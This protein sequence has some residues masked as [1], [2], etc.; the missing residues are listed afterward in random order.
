MEQLEAR[1]LSLDSL[2]VSWLKEAA[3][4]EEK[5]RQ[6]LLTCRLHDDITQVSSIVK[7]LSL[8]GGHV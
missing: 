3:Q 2:R 4:R 7:P 5:Q 8:L 6:D 1:L